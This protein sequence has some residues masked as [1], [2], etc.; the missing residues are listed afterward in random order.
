MPDQDLDEK[1]E[2]NAEAIVPESTP[3][4]DCSH[5][6]SA[7]QDKYLRSLADY[8]NLL[9]QSGREK[10]EVIRYAN[11]SLLGDILPVYN[12][13]KLALEHSGDN[14]GSWIEGVKLVTK[15]FKDALAGAGVAEIE[16]AGK[17]YDHNL[18]DALSEEPTGDQ[19]LD[20]RIAREAAAGYTL[21]GRVLVPAKVTVYKYQAID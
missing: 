21:N 11:Q 2:T 12:N 15:Q 14:T 20:G 16:T 19:S 7:L 8:Q 9:K 6:L 13:L 3:E 17:V 10:A 18:M 5:E 1:V 4:A